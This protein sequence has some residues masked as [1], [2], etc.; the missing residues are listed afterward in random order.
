MIGGEKM[1]ITLDIPE[2]TKGVNVCLVCDNKMWRTEMHTK[3]IG[4]KDLEDGAV[5]YIPKRVIPVGY[6]PEADDGK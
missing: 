6:D 1:R 5:I 2:S 3:L 4:A